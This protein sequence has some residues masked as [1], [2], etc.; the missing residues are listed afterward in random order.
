M[1]CYLLDLP[2]ELQLK[3]IEELIQDENIKADANDHKTHGSHG[4]YQKRE[5]EERI[6]IY[7][8]LINWSCTCSYFRNLLAPNIFK[9]VKLVNK[10]KSGASL[11]AVAESPHKFHVKSLHFV[12]STLIET[13]LGKAAFSDREG[14]L[15]RKVDALLC[16]LQRFPSLEKLSINCNDFESYDEWTACTESDEDEESPKEVLEAE[17]SESWRFLMSRTYF[18]LTQNKSPHFKHLEI[19][20]LIWKNVSTFSHAAFHEFLRHLEQFTLSIHGEGDNGPRRSNGTGEYSVL[21]GKLDQ[22]FFNQLANVTTLSIKAPEEGPLGFDTT[23]HY[24]PLALKA[25]QIPLLK[26]LHLEYIF[27][28]PELIDFLVGH[29]DTLEE[30][31]LC[32]CSASIHAGDVSWS[33]LF[34][35]LFSAHPAQLR[36]FDLVG[37]NIPLTI[38]EEWGYEEKEWEVPG[39]VLEARTILRQDPR[40]RLFAYAFLDIPSGE[41][42]YDKEEILESFWFGHDQESWDRLME[43]VEENA[44]QPRY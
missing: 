14:I 35:S 9:T 5:L 18:A 27:V 16:D 19:R 43:L 28:C 37:H 21:M 25:D 7:H 29:K 44:K 30:L 23:R 15:P 26:T 36:R 34:A 20:Q 31:T 8:D 3:I 33:K 39:K 32:N 11:E 2:A 4:C 22:Y 13:H 24:A 17:A 41:F 38:N 6:C 42:L 40:R 12:G 1:K 10:E